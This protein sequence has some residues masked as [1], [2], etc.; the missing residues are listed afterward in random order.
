MR[1]ILTAGILL[2]GL[3]SA[4]REPDYASLLPDSLHV[5]REK[6]LASPAKL[7]SS[8]ARGNHER[9]AVLPAANAGQQTPVAA[10]QIPAAQAA[11]AAPPSLPVPSPSEAAAEPPV[12]LDQLCSALFSSAQDNDL[13]VAFFANL[14]WQE[15]RLRDDAVSPKGALGIAQFMPKVALA[16]GLE[17]PFD[18]LQ[19]LPA[20][21]RLLHELRDQ[22]GNLGLVAAAYNAGTK[23]VSEW[24]S[25]HRTL[26]RETRFYVLDVT[27]R[28]VEQWQKTP[29]DSAALPLARRLPCRD[30]PAF[31]ELAQTQSQQ[32]QSQGD[33]AQQK[34]AEKPQAQE[35]EQPQRARETAHAEPERL[36]ERK[37][38]RT[39]RR[40]EELRTAER[41]RHR[42]R[43][44]A[45]ERGHRGPHERHGR[46]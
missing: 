40:H 9:I 32:T 7:E 43:H 25:R 14:I 16:S 6:S 20:S 35:M 27:G 21:A 17:N 46:A 33:E 19:A 8:R 15:S 18:P 45:K 23:R 2:L 11:N 12:P 26:P 22:F 39:H 10:P 29:P 30:F 5:G 44:E 34:P 24:L 42:G 4:A 37:H 1:A 38:P 41:D 36:A 28:S 3:S 13:P 31:A